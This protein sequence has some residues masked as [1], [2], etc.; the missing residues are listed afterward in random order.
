MNVT[1]VF[2]GP[3]SGWLG[4]ESFTFEL[5]EGALF[6]DILTGIAKQFRHKMPA[7]LWNDK[8][9]TFNDRVL[10][11]TNDMLIKETNTPLFNNQRIIFYLMV[12]GG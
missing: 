12:A 11:Y 5:F 3:L 6:S 1:V 2:H 7:P 9:N 10:A 4:V 8:K